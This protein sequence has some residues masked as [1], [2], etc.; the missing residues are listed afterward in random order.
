M[1]FTQNWKICSFHHNPNSPRLPYEAITE[2]MIPHKH[3]ASASKN[4]SDFPIA[5]YALEMLSWVRRAEEISFIRDNS[6]RSR[7]R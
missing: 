3:A 1:K 6:W 7:P 5:F 4:A 2:T